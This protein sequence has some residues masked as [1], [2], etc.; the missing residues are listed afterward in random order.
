MSETSNE[1]VLHALEALTDRFEL[2]ERAIIGDE[3]LGHVGLVARLSRVEEA[4]RES[5]GIHLTMEK[6]RSEGDAR[7]HQRVDT[8]EQDF[9]ERLD[10]IDRKL[11]RAIWLVMGAAV[12][13]GLIGG[14]TV[15]T[16]L[17]GG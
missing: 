4:E 13:G 3:K 14:T 10:K 7:V 8:A 16:I 6:N 9:R 15:W 5:S 2:V 12:G 1:V 11:D 17:G